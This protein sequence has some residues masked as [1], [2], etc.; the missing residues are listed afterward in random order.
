MRRNF[1]VATVITL[2]CA[3]LGLGQIALAQVTESRVVGRSTDQ[4]GAVLPGVTVTITSKA[5]GATRTVVTD[6]QGRYTVTNLSPGT[7][8]LV[9]AMS[10]FA[11]VKH[12]VVVGVGDAKTIDLAMT[13]VGITE[14]V[15]LAAAEALATREKARAEKLAKIDAILAE[16]DSWPRTGLKADKAFFDMINGD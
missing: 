8:E 9:T 5:T 11:E 1:K 7:Y 2:V 13:V 12:E 16:V 6:S 14:A 3:V 15:K 10:G 4:T